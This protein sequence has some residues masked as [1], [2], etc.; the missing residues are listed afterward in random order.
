VSALAF[1]AVRNAAR[2]RAEELGQPSSSQEAWRHVRLQPLLQGP[3]ASQ[4][5]PGTVILPMGRSSEP[6]LV[7]TNGVADPDAGPR[8]PTGVILRHYAGDAPA[9]ELFGRW[10]GSLAAENDAAAVWSYAEMRSAAELVID[11]AVTKPLTILGLAVDGGNAWRLRIHLKRGASLQLSVVHLVAEGCRSMPGIEIQL[12]DGARLDFSEVDF[13]A[14]DQQ[15]Y[16]QLLAN[17]SAVIGRDAVLQWGCASRGGSLIRHLTRIRLDAPGAEASLTCAASL[18]DDDQLHH[19]IDIEHAAPR[20]TSRQRSRTIAAGK[21]AF[22]FCGTVRMAVGADGSSAVQ[23]ARAMLLDDR[24]R[25]VQQPR[26][27]IH[28]DEV[29]ASHGAT[30]GRPDPEQIRYLRTRGLAQALAER[31]LLRAFLQE[32]VDAITPPQGRALALRR[33]GLPE[34]GHG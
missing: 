4:L 27:E 34:A 15:R 3:A 19:Q 21:S 26:L 28:A 13:P 11:S 29:Q 18:A 33:L 24:T 30:L 20:T 14:Q 22:G 32:A 2:H 31:L 12:D 5:P 25:V 1:N 6:G 8:L 10:H 9:N 16:G 23:E 17:R 7:F